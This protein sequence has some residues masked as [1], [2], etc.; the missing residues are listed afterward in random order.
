MKKLAKKLA[1]LSLATAVAALG[2]CGGT[3]HTGPTDPTS[4]NG[5]PGG[6]TAVTPPATTAALFH[7]AAGIF[8]YPND[9]Y[10]AGSTDG[11]L[12][13]QPAS[14]LQ[15]NQAAINAL[16][17]FSTNASIR[18]RFAGAIDAASLATPGAVVVAH[19]KTNNLTKAPV[20]PLAGGIL[21]PLVGCVA[22]AACTGADYSVGVAADDPTILEIIPLHPL[23][24]STCIPVPPATTSPCAAANGGS[25]EGYVVLL[26]KAITVG[27]KAAVADAD[28][29]SIQAALAGGATC[30]GITDATLNAI[31]QL[32][33]AHL[34]LG[35]ALGVNPANVIVSFSFSTESTVDSLLALTQPA[36]TPPQTLKLNATGLPTSAANPLLPGHANLYV[37]VLTIPYYLSATQPLTG[38]WQASAAS[39]PDQTSTNVTRF[40]PVPVATKMLQIPVLATV[41]NAKSLAVMAGATGP[42]PVV[43]FQHGIT[44]S[45]EDMLGVADSF[46]DAGFAVVAVD[47]PLHG[48][49]SATDPLYASS[50]NPL[51]AGLGL[52]ASQTSIERTFDLK[53]LGGAGP[54]PSGTSYIN[55]AS[56]LTQRDNLR[57]GA[58]DLIT[59]ERSIPGAQV[60]N[61]GNAS[62]FAA[63]HTHYLGHSQGAIVGI[64]FLGV[65][66]SAEVSTGTL[67]MPGG[68]ITQL[69]LNSPSFAGQINAGLEAQGLIPGTTLYAQFI[70][71]TQTAIDAGDPVNYIAQTVALHPIHLL[72]V[73]GSAAPPAGC[74]PGAMQ[75]PGCPD[76]VVPNSA[77][78]ALI[79]ASAYGPGGAAT[80]LTRITA[81]QAPLVTSAGG[82]R[83]YVQFTEGDHGSIIDDVVPAVTQEM[84]VE[85]ISFVGS[86]IPPVVNA[87]TTPGTTLVL[88]N[89]AVI[90]P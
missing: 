56:V 24:A 10:F 81:G 46:A 82:I 61:A 13:I 19:I 52:P 29:A 20:S 74:G 53:T 11:S 36:L 28:Y 32:T 84:Q 25:G 65:V 30:P 71:D 87:P 78:A 14:A 15:P 48:V 69:I 72:E 89:P 79:T 22:G 7:P 39:A 73:V 6:G 16:D 37:G 40:N 76:Q 9:L 38:F 54:D 5:N 17:G 1:A 63:G 75:M 3:D 88:A 42:W 44:R 2:G 21:V 57:E 43:I 67:A 86:P 77:T 62:I 31:C 51:Y 47:L 60:A 45:R 33:G 23:A 70:R 64:V 80:A 34:A 55:L 68:N 27:G 12:N 66:Q 35:Q 41:P 4:G 8:P 90:K 26:T 83:G 50:Q 59:L 18:E 49:T 85:A 58:A